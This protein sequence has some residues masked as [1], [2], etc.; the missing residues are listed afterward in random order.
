MLSV[1]LC[2][3]ESVGEPYPETLQITNIMF[4]LKLTPGEFAFKSQQMMKPFNLQHVGVTDHTLCKNTD[5]RLYLLFYKEFIILYKVTVAPG[6][7]SFAFR[8]VMSFKKKYF[9]L[10][11]NA[12]FQV[13]GRVR[14]LI[15]KVIQND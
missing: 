6:G 8:A 15:K 1:C 5:W 2:S 4:N 13:E 7:I 11:Q 3:S 9:T 12:A 14:S 10:L